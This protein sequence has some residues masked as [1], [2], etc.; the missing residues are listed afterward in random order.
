MYHSYAYLMQVHILNTSVSG[1]AISLLLLGG[2]DEDYTPTS[3]DCPLHHR[4][5]HCDDYQKYYALN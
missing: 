3:L 5:G 1:D 4:L 2:G